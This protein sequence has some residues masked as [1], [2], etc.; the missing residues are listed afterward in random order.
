MLIPTKPGKEY[1]MEERFWAQV[2]KRGKSEC[3]PWTGARTKHGYGRPMIDGKRV[4]A[5]RLALQF[6]TGRDPEGL[7]ALHSC[8]NPNC[9]NPGHLRWGTQLE[10]IC[11]RVSRNRNGAARGTANG[12]NKL[13]VEQVRAIRADQRTSREIAREYGISQ[14]TVAAIK[15]GK[16]WGWV[17]GLAADKTG[18]ASVSSVFGHSP[19]QAG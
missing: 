12:S 1:S 16:I 5:H 8:D 6:A 13:S 9:V 2:E 14:P 18:K 3:W 15:C 11:D 19:Q 4:M 17:D 7:F 10:N